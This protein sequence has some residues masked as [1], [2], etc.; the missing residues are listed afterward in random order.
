MPHLW[1]TLEKEADMKDD[2]VIC[3]RQAKQSRAMAELTRAVQTLQS[4]LSQE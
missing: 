3:K 1:F 2:E 4:E